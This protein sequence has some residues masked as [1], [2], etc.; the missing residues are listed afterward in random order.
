MK[1]QTATPAPK[2][3][4]ASEPSQGPGL[5]TCSAALLLQARGEG[6]GCLA[7]HCTCSEQGPVGIS[8]NQ[9]SSHNLP[10]GS[11]CGASLKDSGRVPGE[12]CGHW[13]SLFCGL[14]ADIR[15]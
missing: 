1:E 4:A 14:G 12:L 11:I 3:C 13:D 2:P 7:R 6:Q 9:I 5:P 8:Q 15:V 10:H